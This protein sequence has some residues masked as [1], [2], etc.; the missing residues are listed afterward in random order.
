MK[1]A[2]SDKYN[3][4]W[5]TIAQCVARKEKERALGVYRL[6]S[7]SFEDL[8]FARQLEGDIL[9]SFNDLDLAQ[10]KYIQAIVL[11]KQ[12]KRL[13]EAAGVYEH[14]LTIDPHNKTNRAEIIEV[15]EQLGM[16]DKA[17]GHTRLLQGLKN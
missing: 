15:Y 17:Q 9:L 7:H 6:L 8:A 4:A 12:S 5:F 14:L 2:I 11:Y 13:R 10:E 1:Q 16:A 3:I